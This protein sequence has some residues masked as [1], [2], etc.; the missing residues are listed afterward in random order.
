MGKIKM[1]SFKVLA[2][3]KSEI[4]EPVLV[5]FPQTAPSKA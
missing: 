3:S 2:T 1:T 5:S 4:S